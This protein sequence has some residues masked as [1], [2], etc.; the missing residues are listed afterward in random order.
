MPPSVRACISWL[1]VIATTVVAVPLL[2]AP[3]VAQV[4]LPTLPQV[5]LD[6]TY[7]SPTGQTI[8]VPAGGDF[9][10]ALNNAQLGDVITLQAGATFTGPFTLPAKSGSGWIYVQSSALGSLPATGHR[11]FPAQ[12]NLM[13]KIV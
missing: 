7:T 2:P 4:V 6:T 12:A 5:F 8:A 11:V 3:L 10:G 1:V 9:Q 13:P